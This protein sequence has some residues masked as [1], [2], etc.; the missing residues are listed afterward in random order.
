M[1]RRRKQLE[2]PIQRRVH[3]FLRLY[4]ALKANPYSQQTELSIAFSFGRNPDQHRIETNKPDQYV[5]E[6]FMARFQQLIK[7]DDPVF[8]PKILNALP[9]HIDNAELRER[10]RKARQMWTAAEGVPSPIAPLVL[11]AFASGHNLA[12]LYL[13]GG[14]F[15]SDPE[16]SDIWDGLTANDQEFVMH[17]FRTYEGRVRDIIVELKKVIDEARGGG[18]LRDE[19]LDTGV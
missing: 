18:Y 11:G 19:A 4:A 2:I 6:S 5:F 14:V 12:R 3:L 15:H 16:L 13:H 8:L 7:N 9:R 1:G 10:L 17:A